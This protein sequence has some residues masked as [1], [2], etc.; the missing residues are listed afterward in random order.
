MLHGVFLPPF[1]ELADPRTMAALAVDAEQSGWDGFF[2]WDHV[3]RADDSLPVSDPWVVL[4]AVAGATT[5]L[6]IGP[7]VTPLPRRRPWVLARQTVTLD[8]LSG[9]RLTLGVGLGNDRG[10]ELSAFGEET[11]AR[12]RARLLD[13][14][15]DILTGLWAG[16]RVSY[17]AH[18]LRVDAVRF[19]PSPVQRPRI[20]IWVGGE[21]PNRAPMRRAAR[22]DG[23]F[24]VGGT[25]MG[26]GEVTEL[27]A[28][29]AGH[30]PADAGPFDVVL[31]GRGG[32]H[33]D[34][35]PAD[36]DALEAAGVTWW[37]EAL[38][39]DDTLADT[40]RLIAAGP[41]GRR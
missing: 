13:A 1:G 23:V 15:L 24:P 28:V 30:R 4:A 29:V 12:S 40:R 16:E 35:A 32:A 27:L 33:L 41:P 7:L 21:W 20:P 36:L 9:G 26:P 8:H 10:R 18:G 14:S 6:R 22:Y 25:A 3:V 17:D 39:P 19:T 37:L 31:R 34:G 38:Q 5:R 2:V 11:D